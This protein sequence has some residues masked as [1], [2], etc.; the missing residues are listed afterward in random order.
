MDVELMYWGFSLAESSLNVPMHRHNYWQ[1]SFACSG[2]CVFALAGNRKITVRAGEILFLPPGTE[3]A[4]YYNSASPYQSYTFKFRC[5]RPVE[6]KLF[7]VADSERSRA[8]LGA[9]E[10]LM[11]SW[12]PQEHFG[13]PTGAVVLPGDRHA[14]VIEGVLAG[15]LGYELDVARAAPAWLDPL[16][17]AL[18]SQPRLAV[19]EAAA[20]L[21]MSRNAFSAR[22]KQE[23]GL[24]AKSW[25]DRELVR[26]ARRYLEYSDLRIGEIAALLGFPD[27]FAFDAF[28]RRC[29][30]MTPGMCR[31][32]S[33]I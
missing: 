33:G 2:E 12:F 6:E 25:L 24:G 10:L 8:L 5:S 27:V 14:A 16:Y 32:Q 15:V 26:T 7:H 18:R 21:K 29:T 9:V 11:K 20:A 1:S 17:A 19:R 31:R 13:D 4:L 28:F 30:G 23:T 3:H 22:L